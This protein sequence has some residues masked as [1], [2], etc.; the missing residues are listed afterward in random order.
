MPE[1]LRVSVLG[2]V[3]AW[4]ADREIELGAARQRAVF[5]V[6]AAHAGRLVGRDELI[7]AIWGDS[8]PATAA[9]SVYTYVSGLRRAL[10]PGLLTTASGGYLLRVETADLDAARF[11]QLRTA[12]SELLHAGDGRA[13]AD[14]LDEALELWRGDAYATLAGPFLELD[15]QRLAELRLATAEQRARILLDRGGDD[16]LIAELTGL[17]KDNPLHEPLHELLM[18]AL[19][20][21]GRH[22]EAL[23][24][25]RAARRT[26]VAELGIEPGPALQELQRQVL[27]GSAEQPAALPVPEPLRTVVPTAVAKALRDGLAGRDWFGRG[28][29]VD[30]LRQMVRQ[31]AGGTG[32]SIWIEGEPGIGKTELLTHAF[33]DAARCGCR[34]AWGAADQLGSRVPCRCCPGPSAWSPPRAARAARSPSRMSRRTRSSPR[35]GRRARPLR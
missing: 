31:V 34:V 16:G 8:P 2:P 26:L 19:H 3:R 4:I 27:A 32:G 10:T 28:A 6:L 14:R 12:A 1:I 22:A 13:A 24:V 11:Q 33:A 25:F 15:R 21:A 30:R 17:V 35:S 18:R 23:E 29:E 9:G 7:T 20:R 5:A